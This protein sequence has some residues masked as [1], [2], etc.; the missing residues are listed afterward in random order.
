MVMR[1]LK[2]SVGVLFSVLLSLLA[3]SSAMAQ[4]D[5]DEMSARGHIVSLK[6]GALLVRLQTRSQ[7]IETL[8]ERGMEDRAKQLEDQQRKENLEYVEAFV[9]E[10][11]FAPVYFFRSEDSKQVK[12]GRLDEVVFLD[13]QLKPDSSIGVGQKVIYIAEFG[14]VDP[15]DSKIREDYRLENDSTGVKQ[16]PTYYGSANMGFEALVI[17]DD[18]FVQLRRPFPYYVRTFGKKGIMNR[19]PAK[20]VRR[21]NQKLNQF[22]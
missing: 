18:Q 4:K 9:S 17:M 14:T 20:T 22:Y 10:F 2:N 19:S 1:D 13:T 3:F 7:S 6:D 8:M 5:V 15:D 11:D 12:E 21:M 16:K